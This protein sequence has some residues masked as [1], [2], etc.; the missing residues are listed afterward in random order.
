MNELDISKASEM[1]D[2]FCR[3]YEKLTIDNIDIK[4]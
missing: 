3:K 1:L 2:K 4:I